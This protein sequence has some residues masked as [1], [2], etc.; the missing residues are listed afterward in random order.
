MDFLKIDGS[1]VREVHKNPIDFTMVR[2]I[3]DLCKVMGKKTIGEF[4][5]NAEILAILMDLGV[6]YAQG[7]ALGR[8]ELLPI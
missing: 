7:Y 2:S 5:E 3:N 8:P 1:F 4:V 6:D